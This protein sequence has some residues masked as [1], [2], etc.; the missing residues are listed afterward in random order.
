MKRQ[1]LHAGALGILGVA[2]LGAASMAPAL[3]VYAN[4]GPMYSSSGRATPLVF[5]ISLI[6][7][8][9]TALSYALISGEIPAAGSAYTW[10]SQSVN[11]FCG[12]WIGLIL[13]IS[14]A[15]AAILQPILFGTFFNVLLSD[16]FGVSVGFGTWVLGALLSMLIVA[17]LVYP[18]IELSARSSFVLTCIEVLSVFAL[19]CTILWRSS[20][21]NPLLHHP[22]SASDFF[23]DP[24]GFSKG[25]VFGL[26]SF[27]GF[28]VITTTAE[29][30]HSPRSVIP[31]VMV[32]SCVFIGVLWAFCAW[33]FELGLAPEKWSAALGRGDNP[34]LSLAVKYWG[35]GSIMV[36]ITSL[37][38]VLG[39]YVASVIGYARTAW[40][41]GQSLEL[42]SALGS[43][44]PKF[45]TPW[46]AQ[47]LLFAITL[48]VV[49]FWGYI[50]GGEKSYDWWGTA[51]VIF[52]MIP[53]LFV[54]IG[55]AL[56]F[57][58]SRRAKF[59]WLLHG[60]SPFLGCIASLIPLYFSCGVDLWRAG[61]KN[62]GS[63]IL[64]SL[65]TLLIIIPYVRARS[66]KLVEA[67]IR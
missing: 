57:Y 11:R 36:L 38:A 61:W 31:K 2:G 41:M 8:L 50:F 25:L 29:E 37:T 20:S 42:P 44:H 52:S 15:I 32:L 54:N 17:A 59:N 34:V 13:L 58:R 55:C 14:Y 60:I 51:L 33:A 7:T 67:E 28:Q 6:L 45:R 53:N 63:I 3:G 56:F 1:K 47:H 26:L 35:V 9:P 65:G 16:V 24:S 43:L 30:T 4:L 49:P 5:I 62:G 64:F 46:N 23:G 66:S 10:L 19:A 22:I 40:A 21:A 48:M 27:V 18:A 12:A 39:T